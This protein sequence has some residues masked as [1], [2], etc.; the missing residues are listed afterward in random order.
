MVTLGGIDGYSRLITFLQCS[1]NNQASTML[2]LFLSAVHKYKVPSRVRSDHGLENVAVGRYMIETRDSERNSMITG[3]SVHNQRIERLWRDMH[4]CVTILYYKL[5]YFLEHHGILDPLNE[6]HLWALHYVFVPRIN[7]ALE[8]FVNS[9]NHHSIRT[10]GHQSPHQLFTAGCLLLQ[11]SQLAAL[12]FFDVADEDYG[13]DH[14]GPLPTADDG[15]GIQVPN[16]S[17]QFSATDIDN[18]LRNIDPC[19]PSDTFGIEIY[20]QTLN[21]ISAFELL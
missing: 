10:A 20:E 17:I 19:G 1:S 5:F 8:E 3:S 6:H 4:K 14:D 18:L 9:W 15:V 2:R 11:H 21:Y 7:R 13:L 12:D 16:V